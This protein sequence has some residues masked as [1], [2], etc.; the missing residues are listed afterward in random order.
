MKRILAVIAALLVAVAIFAQDEVGTYFIKPMAGMN[1]S[2]YVGS[3]ANS[4]CRVGFTGGVEVGY[5]MSPNIA[6]SGGVLFSM[7]GAKS[8][9]TDTDVTVHANYLNMPILLNYYIFKGM[10]IKAG[11]QPGINVSATATT[12]LPGR[13]IDQDV[14]GYYTFD[15]S[16]PVGLSY[17]WRHMVLDARYNIGLTNVKEDM[18]ARNS[19]FQLTLGYKFRM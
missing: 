5:Q 4:K 11:V 14:Q 10:A 19:V 16:I 13:S 7:Q 17:E 8:D 3:D 12:E 6:V 15:L 9:K 1:V 18:S 2:N